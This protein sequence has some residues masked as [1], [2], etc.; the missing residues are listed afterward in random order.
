LFSRP[1][2]PSSPHTQSVA[3]RDVADGHAGGLQTEVARAGGQASEKRNI[4]VV[5]DLAEAFPLEVFPDAVGLTPS[6]RENLLPYSS[7]VFNSFGP[8]N[9]IFQSSTQAAEPVL[10]W[11][12]AQ[13]A[14]GACA[15]V[16]FAADIWAAHD[17]GEITAEEAP[18]LVRSLLTAGLDTTVNGFANAI[19][20]FATHPEQWQ[21]VRADHPH[22]ADQNVNGSPRYG[23]CS[24]QNA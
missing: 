20:A 10:A 4:E 18:I 9:Q 24:R 14:R 23:F 19:L 21:R 15:D 1:I 7:M 2:P 17:A 12:H 22:S 16:G 6:G 11:I 13:C 5:R 3:A 8:R